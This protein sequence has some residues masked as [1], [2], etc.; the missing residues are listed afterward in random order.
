MNSAKK[1][2]GDVDLSPD[3]LNRPPEQPEE[4]PGLPGFARWRAVYWFVLAV[5]ILFIVL[6]RAFQGFFS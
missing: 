3:S 2:D 6:M 4:S 1:K 5:F